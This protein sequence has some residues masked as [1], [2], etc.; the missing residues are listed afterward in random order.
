MI[1]SYE[2]L[3]N[4]NCELIDGIINVLPKISSFNDSNKETSLYTKNKLNFIEKQ[5]DNYQENLNAVKY[6]N[7]LR[8][9]R[10]TLSDIDLNEPEKYLYLFIL[11]SDFIHI[12]ISSLI[13]KELYKLKT[14]NGEDES[15]LDDDDEE[16]YKIFY[17]IKDNLFIID[18]LIEVYEKNPNLIIRLDTV[19][20]KN[21]ER[22]IKVI[23][24][25]IDCL[26]EGL[27][28]YKNEIADSIE[29]L[30]RERAEEPIL[31]ITKERYYDAKEKQHFIFVTTN[32]FNF[33]KVNEKLC[34]LYLNTSDSFSSI[35]LYNWYKFSLPG[36]V[37]CCNNKKYKE[38]IS[39]N[40]LLSSRYDLDNHFIQMYDH[41]ANKD[42]LPYMN[43]FILAIQNFIFDNTIEVFEYIKTSNITREWIRTL[44]L[45]SFEVRMNVYD[46]DI[47]NYLHKLILKY[48]HLLLK[49]EELRKEFNKFINSSLKCKEW[50][51]SDEYLNLTQYSSAHYRN[52]K[53]I[54]F[55][56]FNLAVVPF[57]NYLKKKVT[58]RL[59]KNKKVDVIEVDTL[60]NLITNGLK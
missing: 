26:I 43:Y 47:D 39:S 28:L 31:S 59:D 49:S 18:T 1:R 44:I 57:I 13:K 56:V 27:K 14:E 53:V 52:H 3:M 60:T 38:S 35:T 48:Y 12:P 24:N 33:K 46:K 58:E 20:I 50:E 23:T 45:T 21:K 55:T 29:N 42:I 10:L 19:T 2:E 16:T 4:Y 41:I 6:L 30:T 25:L 34:K 36:I 54:K 22:F 17:K 9:E 40:K 5:M 7:K 37:N 32:S 51:Y 8:K 11:I 15:N